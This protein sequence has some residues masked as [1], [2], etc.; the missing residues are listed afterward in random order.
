VPESISD[1]VG[2][3]SGV[4]SRYLGK[5][6]GTQRESF[7]IAGKEFTAVLAKLKKLVEEELPALEKKLDNFDAPW[8]P[9]RLPE[10]K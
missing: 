5:P 3:A 10:W 4:T 1:R 7:A 9:G 8:T 2:Y 6:T